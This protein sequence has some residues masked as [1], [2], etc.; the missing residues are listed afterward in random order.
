MLRHV[1]PPLASA[2]LK[3][4]RAQEHLDPLVE[5]IRRFENSQPYRVIRETDESAGEHLAYV[6]VD[7]I[8]G[9]RW[10]GPLGD[11]VHN[12]RGTLDHAV[13]GLSRYFAGRPLTEPEMKSIE[14][15]ITTD[16]D[17]WRRYVEGGKQSIRFLPDAYRQI[18]ESEQPYRGSNDFI[19]S[20]HPMH[21]LKTLWNTDKHRT[22]PLFVGFGRVMLVYV[23]GDPGF[24]TYRR[25]PA[26]MNNGSEVVRVPIGRIKSKEDLQPIVQVE[27]TL[28]EGGPTRNPVGTRQPIGS[29]LGYMHNTVF[30]VLSEFE[31]LLHSG[32]S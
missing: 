3:L 12:L 30:E 7:G 21:V 22:I 19:R 28:Q 1:A 5:D 6:V 20:N 8:P 4:I 10:Y 9:D 29:F 2:Y 32:V 15:P 16:P 24:S 27:V 11:T 31:D 13:H 17:H 14:F 23:P 25:T 18:I 26:V